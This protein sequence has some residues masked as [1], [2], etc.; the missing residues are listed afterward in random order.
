MFEEREERKQSQEIEKMC[1]MRV[2][3]KDFILNFPAILD[4]VEKHDGVDVSEA[5]EMY[6]KQVERNKKDSYFDTEYG[7]AHA[8]LVRKDPDIDVL[9]KVSDSLVKK[10]LT[11]GIEG[12]SDFD[13][14]MKYLENTVLKE[15][16]WQQYMIANAKGGRGSK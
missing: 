8:D 5:K 3:R 15:V 2:E 14:S 1:E 13:R 9:R 6:R 11:D 12:H 16:L 7:K 10:G 4:Y